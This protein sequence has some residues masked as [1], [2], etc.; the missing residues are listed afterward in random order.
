MGNETWTTVGAAVDAFLLSCTP[1]EGIESIGGIGGIGG[2]RR[3]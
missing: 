2:Y 3:V 1:I